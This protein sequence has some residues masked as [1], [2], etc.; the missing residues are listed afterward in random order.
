MATEDG[1]HIRF[2]L[3]EP[4]PRKKTLFWWVL[5]KHDLTTLGGIGWFG[6]W[7]K[8]AFFP[9]RD[10]A[11]EEVCLRELAAFC[12]RKTVEHKRM[13]KESPAKSP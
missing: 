2:T 12:E 8:Y 7:R 9:K 11:Y 3:R 13:R 10:T 5:S 1:T 6:R 4:D